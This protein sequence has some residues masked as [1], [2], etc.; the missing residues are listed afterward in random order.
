MN[1]RDSLKAIGLTA[2]STAVLLE[3][4]KQPENTS[5]KP[6]PQETKAEAG[7]EQWEVDRDKELKA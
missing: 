1:R 2:V 6:I 7:R 3:A 4:C 5:D